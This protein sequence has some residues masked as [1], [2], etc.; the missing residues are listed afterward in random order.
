MF[1]TAKSIAARNAGLTP[2]R[3]FR[4][5]GQF[6]AVEHFFQLGTRPPGGF[7]PGKQRPM[8]IKQLFRAFAVSRFQ[9]QAFFRAGGINGSLAG[10]QEF[11]CVALSAVKI[12]P[13]IRGFV[14]R[15]S[16]SK[17]EPRHPG[18]G[19]ILKRRRWNHERVKVSHESDTSKSPLAG[20]V[21]EA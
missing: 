8:M 3:I 5:A 11:V 6:V 17:N 2:Q 16:S 13:M 4:I 18:G 21:V 20:S 19:V 15:H 1:L 14:I 9:P 7:A 10:G 12:R